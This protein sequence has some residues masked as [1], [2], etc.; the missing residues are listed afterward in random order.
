MTVILT[1]PKLILMAKCLLGEFTD[2]FSLDSFDIGF[3]PLLQ[4]TTDTT[5][6]KPILVRPWRL[7]IHTQAEVQVIINDMLKFGI[8]QPSQ[9]PW[10]APAVVVAKKGWIQ[11]TLCRLSK[12]KQ[13]NH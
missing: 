9:G 5:Q 7:P 6:D 11:K 10:C 4:N 12:T 13:C 3:T 8:I 2:I 1:Q